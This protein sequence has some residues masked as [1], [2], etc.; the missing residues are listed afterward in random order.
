MD[1]CKIYCLGLLACL[2]LTLLN[3]CEQVS[4]RD[5]SLETTTVLL[6]IGMDG[7]KTKLMISMLFPLKG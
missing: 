5:N 3:G 7:V 1:R 6:Q 4:V 2:I